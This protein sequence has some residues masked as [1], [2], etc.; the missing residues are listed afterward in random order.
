MDAKAGRLKGWA[1]T[2]AEKTPAELGRLFGPWASLPGGFGAGERTRLFSPLQD[3][4]AL[5][6]PGARRKGLL[7]RSPEAVPGMAAG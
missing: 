1:R 4:L 6:L 2:M 3:L 7:P 5:S